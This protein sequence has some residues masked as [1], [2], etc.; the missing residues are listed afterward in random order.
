MYQAFVFVD[1]IDLFQ[2]TSFQDIK[3]WD[4]ISP[5]YSQITSPIISDVKITVKTDLVK[6]LCS[7]K[8]STQ[9]L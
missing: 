8:L 9:E 3:N 7:K 6:M 2:K 4:I 5:F 1:L